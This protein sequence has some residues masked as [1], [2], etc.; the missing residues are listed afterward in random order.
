MG[1]TVK[2]LDYSGENF[3][4][5]LDTHLKNLKST[6]LVGNTFFKTFS[7]DPD[8]GTLL[9]YLRKNFPGGNYFTAYQASFSGFGA[10]RELTKLGITN[11]AVNS[12]DIPTTD[13]ER[14]QKEDAKDSRKIEE[15]LAASKL[16]GIH[17][18]GIEREGDRSMVRFRKTLTKE[19]A[20]NKCRA[21]S[22]LCY[23]GIGSSNGS[24]TRPGGRN[25]L[26]FG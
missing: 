17:V 18:P 11:I 26:P 13:K 22:F 3:Y 1:R 24:P 5:G 20:R 8:A 10:H 25:A 19:I 15:Q 4:V 21:K 2:R 23:H 9:K 16:E 14:K 12:A 7:N 6:V